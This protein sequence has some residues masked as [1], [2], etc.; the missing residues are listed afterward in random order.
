MRPV[1]PGQLHLVRRNAL[2][3]IL[4]VDL[5]KKIGL[6]SVANEALGFVK[7]GVPVRFGV[8]PV[9]DNA[10]GKIFFYI[11]EKLGREAANDYI[12]TVSKQL[13]CVHQS[14]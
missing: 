3:A 4:A 13:V 12:K 7:R 1:Y 9:G 11:N 14:S 8:V 6:N 5:S 2:N 10:A